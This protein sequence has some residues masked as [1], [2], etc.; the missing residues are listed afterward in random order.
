M[1]RAYLFL[2]VPSRCAG[3]TLGVRAP[4]G[5]AA[6]PRK[7]ELP[8]HRSDVLPESPRNGESNKT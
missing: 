5:T 6:A 7:G 3:Q 8:P 1:R 4:G 2:D